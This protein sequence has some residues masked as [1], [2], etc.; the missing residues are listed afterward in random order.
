MLNQSAH[1]TPVGIVSSSEVSRRQ[2]LANRMHLRSSARDV[3]IKMISHSCYTRKRKYEAL[4]L[5][6]AVLVTQAALTKHHRLGSLNN[7]NV[8]YHSS[9]GWKV[10]DQGL[11]SCEDSPGLQTATFSLYPHMTVPWWMCNQR[12]WAPWYLL[13]NG[14]QSF[15][16]GALLMISFGLSHFIRSTSYIYCH[17]GYWGF[18]HR[19]H[20]Q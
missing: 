11:V 3:E 12:K 5:L 20:C 6:K 15:Q 19:K 7:I 14:H 10:K 2:T 13:L 4:E 17:I 1:S 9:R 16:I 8:F 18:Q